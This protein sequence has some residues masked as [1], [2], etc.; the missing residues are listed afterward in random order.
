MISEI[1]FDLAF[2]HYL[3]QGQ[4]RFSVDFFNNTN[5][6]FTLL[7]GVVCISA[8][9][10]VNS[11]RHQELALT[12]LL[13]IIVLYF[14]INNMNKGFIGIIIFCLYTSYIFFIRHFCNLTKKA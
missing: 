4:S 11:L 10:I 5:V 14:Y 6:F 7:I 8:Y 1:P 9:N 13:V 3:F 12:L 2:S